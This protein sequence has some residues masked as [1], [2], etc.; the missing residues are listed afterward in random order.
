MNVVWGVAFTK[1]Q[2][3]DIDPILVAKKKLQGDYVLPRQILQDLGGDSLKVFEPHYMGQKYYLLGLSWDDFPEDETK[4]EFIKRVTT[5]LEKALSKE[6][7]VKMF[8]LED[9]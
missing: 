3:M 6:V 9:Y 7:Y 4:H 8:V 2:V 5:L 1:K